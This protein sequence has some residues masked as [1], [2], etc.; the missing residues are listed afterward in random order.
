MP[1]PAGNA[2][3]GYSIEEIKAFVPE[4]VKHLESGLSRRCFVP[5][6]YRTIETAIEKNPQELHTEKNAI[7]KAE[8]V[9]RAYWES[10]G[11]DNIVNKKQM[12]KESDGSTTV[13]ETSLNAAAW[14]FTMKNKYGDEWRDKQEIEGEVQINR[15]IK[16]RPMDDPETE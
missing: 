4:Y 6:D 15:V 12:V 2:Y 7:A 11:R 8:R 3:N 1:A 5:C 10:I 9:G 16:P 13:I 14:I